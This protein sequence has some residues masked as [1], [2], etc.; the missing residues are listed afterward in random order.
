MSLFRPPRIADLEAKK[1]FELR[2]AIALLQ[3]GTKTNTGA[4]SEGN[5]I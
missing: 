3:A 1:G 5:S 2:M 4:T